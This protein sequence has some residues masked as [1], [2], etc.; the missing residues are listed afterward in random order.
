MVAFKP[1]NPGM[2]WRDRPVERSRGWPCANA[3]A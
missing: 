2:Q 3:T 1:D